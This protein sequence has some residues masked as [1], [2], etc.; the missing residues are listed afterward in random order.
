MP[1]QRDILDDFAQ[2]VSNTES[3]LLIN[4]RRQDAAPDA[5]GNYHVHAMAL[6]LRHLADLHV[7]VWTPAKA[8]APEAFAYVHGNGFHWQAIVKQ[9]LRCRVMD[10]KSFQVEN[11]VPF[12]TARSRR[13]MVLSCTLAPTG[14]EMDYDDSSSVPLKPPKK[15]THDEASLL[16]PESILLISGTGGDVDCTSY[17]SGTESPADLPKKAALAL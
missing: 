10:T 4:E 7:Q 15:R 14:E 9:G 6:T 17:W 16:E 8:I 1:I 12:L 11:L 3:S 2:H 13:G 5:Q